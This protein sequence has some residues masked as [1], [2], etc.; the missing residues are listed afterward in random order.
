MSDERKYS[1][2]DIENKI[3]RYL[4][5]HDGNTTNIIQDLPEGT[6]FHNF[7]SARS[8]LIS[9]YP[10]LSN[11]RVLEIGAGMG[12]LTVQLAQMCRQ[13]VALEPSIKRAQIISLRCQ[14]Y[15]N[16]EVVPQGIDKYRSEEKFDYV[17]LIGVLEYA[18]ISLKGNHPWKSMLNMLKPFLKENGKVLLAIENKFGLKYWCGAAEDHTGIPFDS[19]NNYQKSKGT[20]DRYQGTAGVRTFSKAELNNMFE[21]TGLRALKYYYPLPDYKFPMLILSD[22]STDKQMVTD[23][24]YNYPEESYLIADPRKIFSEIVQN[25][26]MDFFANSFLIEI[27]LEGS[28]AQACNRDTITLKRDYKPQYRIDTIL[29]K[30]IVL[31][32]SE[33]TLADEHLADLVENTEILLGKGIPCV[34]QIKICNGETEAVRVDAPRAD[35]VFKQAINDEDF[36]LAFEMLEK[37]RTYILKSGSIVE[38]N[39]Q[40]VLE[41][42]F[43]DL[44]FR[45]SFW[46]NNDLL[47]FDQEWKT[48][49]VSM[50]FI[51]FRS[52][53]YAAGTDNALYRAVLQYCGLSTE[54]MQQLELQEKDFLNSLMDSENCTWFDKTMYQDRLLYENKVAAQLANKDMHIAQLEQSERDLQQQLVVHNNREQRLQQELQDRNCENSTLLRQLSDEKEKSV[55]LVQ[56]LN[57]KQ[58]HIELLLESDRELERIKNSRSWRYMSYV[59]KI[60]DVLIPCGSKRRMLGKIIVKFVKHPIRFIGKCSPARIHKFFITL[61]R[62]GTEGVSRRLDDCLI[63]NN[64]QTTQLVLNEVDL[65]A[66]KTAD[67]YEVLYVPAQDKPVISIVIPVYNQFEYTYLCIKSILEN[68]GDVAYEIIIADD[69]STDLTT[70]IDEIIHGVH[71]IHNESNLRFLRNCNNAA[72]QARGQY[73]LFLNNDTQVQAD[74]LAPLIELIERDDSIGMVGSKLVYPDGRLQEAGGILWQDGSAWN[75]GNRANPDEPEFN[76]VKEADYIS[77]A[78]IM[79]RKSLWEEIGGFDERFVPAYCEDSDLAF[80]VRKHGCK[81]M[82]QPKSVVVHFEGVSNGTDT[83]SG[84]KA[85]QV[86]NQKKFLEKWQQELQENHLP[87]AVDPFRARERSVHKKILL[88][89]DHYVPHYDKDAGS[90]TVYQY[91]QLFVNQGF[92]VKFIGDNFF[93]HQPYTDTLQQMGVEVLYGPYYAKHWKDWLK[94]NGKDIGYVFLNRPHI[95]VKYIDAVREFTNA[96]VIY[97]GHDLHFLR[98]KREYEL[99]G[100]AAL[101]QSSADW[102]KKELDL[103]LAADMA[104]YP[105]YVEEQ[106]IHEIA[107]QAKVKAIPAYLFSD[108][109]E[110]EYHFDKRKDLMFIGGF[111]H[112]PNVDAVKWLA[113]EIMPALVKKLPDIRVYILGSNPPEEVKQLATENLL[114]KGFVTDEELQEYYQNCRISIVPLRYGAGIKGKVIE[115]M[116]FGTPV[117]T[118]SVGAEGIKGAESILDIADETADFVEQLA[119]LYQ[120]EAELVRRSKASYQY[121]RDN[122][123]FENAKK[124]IGPEFDLE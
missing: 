25:D 60:R 47:F 83:T 24:K 14:Q 113:N 57:N 28:S 3:A 89:V 65:A 92:S 30:N 115:A 95:S 104:Y 70:E 45:N 68:S 121:I 15:S 20:T 120:N 96:R 50:D 81:V 110:S 46:T 106:A 32:K 90:R 77:G 76:Y 124:V 84:Q 88:M 94:E 85:Y 118:T 111:G 93:A 91:L 51:M 38:K 54:R 19:I 105:S 117:M 108:V 44:T 79:I 75:Y 55:A 64:I 99:T 86:T 73:I 122:F 7:T 1:D 21:Q 119:A 39:G 34:K 12:A 27:G 61:R 123:S 53:K 41:E 58:G 17:L 72:K 43:P 101:L 5:E 10:F 100:D 67:D 4:S 52:V 35:K 87:N 49:Y 97:Y 71:T 107:P 6:V 78:A 98:E 82:Y 16:V 40:A 109:E 59:W 62:E 42:G 2:G 22:E 69:C 74:W 63:G 9:W 26:C 80:E 56:Q 37:L 116:R 103:I 11:D 23:V 29:E 114:I 66:Q 13:V 33:N 102:E 48:K 31:R 8:N 36:S 112:R 18:G